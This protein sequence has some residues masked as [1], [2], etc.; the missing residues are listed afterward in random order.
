MDLS[1][2]VRDWNTSG[3][4]GQIR[5][6]ATEVSGTTQTG[7]MARTDMDKSTVQPLYTDGKGRTESDR[8]DS[9]TEN[10][11]GGIPD[12]DVRFHENISAP[13]AISDGS[14]RTGDSI[15]LYLN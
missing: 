1:S 2:K 4:T 11:V 3:R 13:S 5:I 10:Q 6:N 7:R 9:G 14:G 8:A 12:S 15:N